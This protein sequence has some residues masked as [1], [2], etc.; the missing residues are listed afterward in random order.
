MLN[1][2]T[3]RP[4]THVLLFEDDDAQLVHDLS[5]NTRLIADC[6][7]ELLGE[8]SNSIMEL[9]YR[10][11]IAVSEASSVAAM[12]ESVGAAL[13]A[14]GIYTYVA[15]VKAEDMIVY[16]GKVGLLSCV[17]WC[18][19]GA[20]LLN[21]VPISEPRARKLFQ[22]A[23]RLDHTSHH[24]VL[25]RRGWL[26]QDFSL[27]LVRSGGEDRVNGVDYILLTLLK[28]DCEPYQNW[29]DVGLQ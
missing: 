18:L 29:V 7:R 16:Q 25:M 21:E 24:L 19:A 5:D 23:N 27:G 22:Q 9:K 15:R 20:V 10:V 3:A 13:N 14:R 12:C 11:V 1:W 4:V 8:D 17:L 2:A 26:Q 28:I 6:H